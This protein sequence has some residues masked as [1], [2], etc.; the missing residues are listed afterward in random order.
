M[1]V[2]LVNLIIMQNLLHRLN[3][4]TELFLE[5]FSKTG[6]SERSVG[7]EVNSIESI[8]MEVWAVDDRLHVACLQAV[9]RW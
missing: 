6:L 2:G 4:A 1:H 9:Q 8:S 7:P 3:H 5:K